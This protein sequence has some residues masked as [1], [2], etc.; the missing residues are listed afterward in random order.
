MTWRTIIIGDVH[1]CLEELDELIKLV[2]LKVGWD[3]LVFVGDLVDRGPDSVGVVRRARELRAILVRGNHEDWYVRRAARKTSKKT[4][5]DLGAKEQL[6]QQLKPDDILYMHGATIYEPLHG[7]LVVH[8]GLE[9]SKP[10]YACADNVLMRCRYVD[11]LTEEYVPVGVRKPLPAGVIRWASRWRGW[12]NVV[13]GHAVYSLEDPIIDSQTPEFSSIRGPT[14]W[15]IDTGCCF[16]GR[17]TAMVIDNG[18]QFV[19]VQAKQAYAEF[20]EAEE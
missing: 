17:L 2:D 10:A 6:F 8:A 15:G 1:G 19:Q 13:Y 16:G 18:H 11:C 7:L 12:E 9:P 3:K 4:G 5:H 14:C 20:I